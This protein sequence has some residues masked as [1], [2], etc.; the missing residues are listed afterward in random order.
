MPTVTNTRVSVFDRI[1]CAFDGSPASLEAAAQAEALRNGLGTI[2]LIGV[3][4]LPATGYSAYGAPLIVAEAQQEFGNRFEKAR[5]I[6]PTASAEILQGSVVPRLLEELDDH[7]ATL[8]AVGATDHSRPVGIALGS[9]ATNLLHRAPCSVL[10]ARR[11]WQ[12]SHPGS[13][14]VGYDGSP[15]ASEAL[16]T[17][18]D[19]A[20]RLDATLTVVLADDAASIETK[21]LDGLTVER[22]ERTPVVALRDAS[23][24]ADLLVVG[25]RGLRGLKAIGSV[26]EQLGHESACSILVVRD[27]PGH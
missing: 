6:C 25:S 17:G 4:R 18:R 20:A 24:A 9:V 5:S 14:V 23:N 15:G 21:E 3:F 27:A 11:A 19:L 16:S 7:H 22:D 8:V 13:I 12:E 10:V 1:V 26:S 2:E